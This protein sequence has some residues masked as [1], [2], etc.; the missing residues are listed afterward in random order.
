MLKPGLLFIGKPSLHLHEMLNLALFLKAPLVCTD[1]LSY[2]ICQKFGGLI[3]I[4]LL[5][6]TFSF[7][8]FTAGLTDLYTNLLPKELKNLLSNR[9]FAK[10]LK[11]YHFIE[12]HLMSLDPSKN[13]DFISSF[14]HTQGLVHE[15]CRF[16]YLGN[17]GHKAYTL[18]KK[19]LTELY[20]QSL[21]TKITSDFP[22]LQVSC[23][24]KNIGIQ[25]EATLDEIFFIKTA[26]SGFE[27]DNNGK[28]P[29]FGLLTA[30]LE[31]TKGAIIEE[32]WLLL[33][34]LQTQKPIFV[35]R[36][37]TDFY[38][39]L[40]GLVSKLPHKLTHFKSMIEH[41]GEFTTL[42]RTQSLKQMPWSKTAEAHAHL[43][44]E[45]LENTQSDELGS[46]VL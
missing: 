18:H 15:S 30:A 20:F 4:H 42:D 2:Q 45:S 38:K 32:E 27:S 44:K 12:P 11:V 39:P 13:V 8:Y 35:T 34:A 43:P 29:G 36:E 9:L 24:A 26:F 6:D 46:S 31:Q 17:I 5:S 41:Y 22:V 25:N 37:L 1:P 7:S 3:P 23:D 33:E 21:K 40:S 16:H 14:P 19:A 28:L 10:P